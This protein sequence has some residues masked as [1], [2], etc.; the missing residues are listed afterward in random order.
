MLFIGHQQ[1]VRFNRCFFNSP[2]P[3][4]CDIMLRFSHTKNV[5]A[6]NYGTIL[7]VENICVIFG[8]ITFHHVGVL[9]IIIVNIRSFIKNTKSTVPTSKQPRKIKF[10]KKGNQIKKLKFFSQWDLASGIRLGGVSG[11]RWHFFFSTSHSIY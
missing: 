2:R 7:L 4:L 3:T 8:E 1:L 6:K 10:V 9:K 5:S 11:S